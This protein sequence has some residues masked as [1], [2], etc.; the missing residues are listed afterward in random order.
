MSRCR[1]GIER[2]D[3]HQDS[4]QNLQAQ[5]FATVHMEALGRLEHR[6][7]ITIAPAALRILTIASWSFWS[8]MKSG[9]APLSV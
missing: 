2:I 3:L 5:H 9:V 1:V 4:I 6:S 8:A 7:G